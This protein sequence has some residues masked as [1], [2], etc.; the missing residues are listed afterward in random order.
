[1]LLKA[2]PKCICQECGLLPEI[3]T[4]T[5][6]SL[7]FDVVILN[8]VCYHWEVRILYF[9]KNSHINIY[10]VLP[11]PPEPCSFPSR[12]RAHFPCPWTGLGYLTNREQK[13]N[14][15]MSLKLVHT[16]QY[17]FFLSSLSLSN[18]SSL[19]PSQH[20]LRK[21]SSH[22]KRLH[23][24]TGDTAKTEV[25]ESHTCEWVSEWVTLQRSL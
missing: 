13:K 18:W 2:L 19:Q 15:G 20:A 4:L 21:P 22:L 11:T 5:I 14:C 8:F 17:G 23:V 16:R 24:S 1:M 25:P 3:P 9:P 7:D 12:S 6:I 10:L